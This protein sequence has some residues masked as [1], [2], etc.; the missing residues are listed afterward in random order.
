MHSS[1]NA[2]FSFFRLALPRICSLRVQYCSF[3]APLHSISSL[4]RMTLLIQLSSKFMCHGLHCVSSDGNITCPR[5]T[6]SPPHIRHTHVHTALHRCLQNMAPPPTLC[7]RDISHIFDVIFESLPFADP[8]LSFC[9]SF[10]TQ[11]LDLPTL[12]G[13]RH[14][15]HP[16]TVDSKNRLPAYRNYFDTFE[17]IEAQHKYVCY[18]RVL[19]CRGDAILPLLII[20]GISDVVESTL[21]STNTQRYLPA[22]SAFYHQRYGRIGSDIKCALRH[23]WFLRTLS[24]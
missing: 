19:T 3:S 16:G 22:S 14:L 24:N 12:A 23:I 10:L 6:L 9:G 1:R 18:I 13:C 4:H 2:R 21:S 5:L 8:P 17:S 15:F 20:T 11:R 7:P